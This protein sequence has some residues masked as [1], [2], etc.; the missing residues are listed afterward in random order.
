MKTK[1]TTINTG[2]ERNVA[3]HF[4]S[5]AICSG[6]ATASLTS[7]NKGNESTSY[8]GIYKAALQ[9][10]IATAGAISAT[11]KIGKGDYLGALVSVALGGAAVYAVEKTSQRKA[12]LTEIEDGTTQ[13]ALPYE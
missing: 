1:K 7:N 12:Q 6:I 2:Q 8:G 13:P 10:G 4:I 5:G 3:G 11:N 9:G